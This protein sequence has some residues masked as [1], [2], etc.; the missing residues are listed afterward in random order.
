MG[1]EG[2]VTAS[3]VIK[4]KISGAGKINGNIN[5][6]M[7]LRGY[8][9]YEVAVLEGFNGTEAEWLAT[10]K[11][12][13]GDTGGIRSVN[14]IE[15]DSNGNVDID[16]P[17]KLP[18]PYAL[19]INGTEYDGTKAV[20]LVIEGGAGGAGDDGIS[21][22]AKVTQTSDGAVITI[23]DKEGTTT[24]TVTNGKDGQDGV[25]PTVSVTDITGGHRV[26]ITDANGTKRI[27][28]L[29]G[30]N[31]NDYVLT[32]ADK[33]EIAGMVDVKGGGG[34]IV[35]PEPPEDTSLLWIDPDDDSGDNVYTKAEIDAMFGAYITDINTLV[36]GDS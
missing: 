16:L 32:E 33:E 5:K 29:D 21:P 12:D 7:E 2:N 15:A 11:G 8:S 9:A 17:T 28:V 23:T 19:T 13:K 27:D 14:G 25:S 31:G 3:K 10:L 20:D 6:L 1:I 22:V 34:F 26:S 18:N 30:K 35:S 4:G 36:G 24:A